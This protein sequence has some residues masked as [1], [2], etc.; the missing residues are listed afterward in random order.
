MDAP[1]EQ[2]PRRVVSLVPSVT[3]SLFD[4]GLG[5]RVRA[6]TD[7]CIHPADQ[8]ARLPRIGGTKNPDVAQIIALSPD[9]VIANQEENRREDVEALQAANIPV[10][11]TFPRTVREAFNLLWTIM[12]IFDEPQMV[13]R[14]RAM[15]WT[16]DWLERMAETREETTPCRV[17]APIWLDPLMTFNADT[18]PH[19]LLRLCGGQNVFAERDRQYPLKADLG[20]AEPYADDDPRVAGR[21][22]RYP[23]ITLAEV[24]AAQPDVILLPSEPFAF[25]ESHIPMFAALDVPAAHHNRIH[26]LDGSLLTWHGTRIARA[27]SVLPDLM[28]TPNDDPNDAPNDAQGGQ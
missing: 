21:D 18:F 5:D 3:E 19:D 12:H 28:C 10:W 13:E 24:E 22:T 25:D 16:V 1:V 4:L 27:V 14:V 2:P 6:I 7:Y 20:E 26:L 23:R 17:F 15:E 8:V 9:L 11:V